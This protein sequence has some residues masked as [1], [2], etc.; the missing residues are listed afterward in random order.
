MYELTREAI[1]SLSPFAI[2]ETGSE[3]KIEENSIIAGIYPNPVNDQLTINLK[4][5]GTQVELLDA[6]GKLVSTTTTGG[7][8]LQ[9][10]FTG[11]PAGY[12]FVRATSGS[13]ISTQKI[14]KQ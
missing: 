4:E 14:V 2:T 5:A 1:T 11:M 3:L 9:L 6:Y 12:Y 10:D 7:N 8:S 13:A